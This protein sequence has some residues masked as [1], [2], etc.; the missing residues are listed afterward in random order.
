VHY[1]LPINILETEESFGDYVAF[2]RYICLCQLNA[3]LHDRLKA[4]AMPTL[5]VESG[6]A[7]VTFPVFLHVSACMREL[8]S[9]LYSLFSVWC[10]QADCSRK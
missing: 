6:V 1:S 3:S 9:H 5:G 7:D 10:C 2:Y 8:C 4:N